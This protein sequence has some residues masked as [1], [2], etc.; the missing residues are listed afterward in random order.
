MAVKSSL[1]PNGDNEILSE[2]RDFITPF[3]DRKLCESKR[4]RCDAS[5]A[6]KYLD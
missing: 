1:F 4:W 6:L 5:G 2:Y 3:I